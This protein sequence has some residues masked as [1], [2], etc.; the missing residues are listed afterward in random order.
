[1]FIVSC[2]RPTTETTQDPDTDIQGGP[3]TVS[4]YQMI[5]KSY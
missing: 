1:L 5:K 2:I 3:K 4:H